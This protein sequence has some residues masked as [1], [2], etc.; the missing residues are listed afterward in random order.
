MKAIIYTSNAGSTVQYAQL[1]ANE[2]HLPV[3]SAKKQRKSTCSF[4]DHLS[5]LD[6]GGGG[7]KGYKDMVKNIMSVQSVP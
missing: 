1:L 3:Y 6:H 5:W 2:L 4:R 7:I